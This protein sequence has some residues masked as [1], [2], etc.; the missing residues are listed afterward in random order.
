MVNEVVGGKGMAGQEIP[1]RVA[2]G[3]ERRPDWK[4]KAERPD[5]K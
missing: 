5:M 4:W 2:E 1:P 3:R